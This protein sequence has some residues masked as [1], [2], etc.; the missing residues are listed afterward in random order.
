MTPLHNLAGIVLGLPRFA[1]RIVVAVVDLSL[2]VLTVWL[3]FYLRL[4]EFVSFSGNSVWGPGAMQAAAASVLL[5][6]PYLLFLVCTG[7]FL[8]TAAHLR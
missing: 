8:G 2:C 7:R 6:F 1:K 4:G 5:A 3:A